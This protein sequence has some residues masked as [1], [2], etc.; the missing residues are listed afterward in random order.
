[1]GYVAERP[2]EGSPI[3]GACWC[4]LFDVENPRNGY[5]ASNVPELVVAVSAEARG[6]GVG[7][8][9]MNRL[10]RQAEVAGAP[11]LSL[12]VSAENARA[13]QLYRTLGFVVVD[14]RGREGI[15]M[16]KQL[17]G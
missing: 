8:A 11:G 2:T 10:I 6:H 5:L 1:M 15:V 4:R 9:L 16:V 14:D 7:R 17:P 3:I 12:H 13:Q